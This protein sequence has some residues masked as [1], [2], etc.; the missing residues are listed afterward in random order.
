M[1]CMEG[2][3][4]CFHIANQGREIGRLVFPPGRLCLGSLFYCHGIWYLLCGTR[5]VLTWR[6]GYVGVPVC[7]ALFVLLCWL[8]KLILRPAFYQIFLVSLCFLALFRAFPYQSL[9]APFSRAV[10]PQIGPHPA[11]PVILRRALVLHG[12]LCIWL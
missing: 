6:G 8:R 7:R 5:I 11:P 1:C 12:G 4:F 2:R 3:Q 10:N 9:R